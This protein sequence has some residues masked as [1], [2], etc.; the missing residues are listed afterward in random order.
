MTLTSVT[1]RELRDSITLVSLFKMTES[2]SAFP[3]FADINRNMSDSQFRQTWTQITTAASATF[4]SPAPQPANAKGMS[5]F[6]RKSHFVF[7]YIHLSLSS[8]YEKSPYLVH[9]KLNTR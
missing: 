6:S 8:V 3:A 9:H 5:L 7:I 4:A 2:T 1:G